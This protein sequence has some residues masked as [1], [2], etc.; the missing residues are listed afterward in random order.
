MPA[1]M[2]LSLVPVPHARPGF[3]FV[4]RGE[5]NEECKGCPYRKLC[6][7]LA[8]GHAYEVRA[9]RSITHPCALHDEGKVRVV[10]VEEVDVPATAAR[11][12][13]KGTALHWTP[14]P[15]GMPACPAYGLCHPVGLAAGAKHEV[16]AT[17]GVQ[18][19][20]AG[21]DLERVRLKRMP[22]P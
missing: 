14:P 17:L 21:F 7:D 16:T 12:H 15:C 1:H 20:P 9:V 5:N 10:E 13:L 19:C 18:P 2:R 4:F 22:E 8:P 11:R 6:F 3:R